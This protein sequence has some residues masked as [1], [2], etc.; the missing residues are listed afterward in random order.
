M[1]ARQVP[2]YHNGGGEVACERIV[3]VGMWRSEVNLRC[4]FLKKV[5]I[6]ILEMVFLVG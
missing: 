3:C 4:C 2:L 5:V 1:N 6:L